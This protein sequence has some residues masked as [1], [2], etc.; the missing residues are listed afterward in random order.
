MSKKINPEC[1]ERLKQWLDIIN[2]NQSE[3]AR[4]CGYS[5]PYINSVIKGKKKLT[6]DLAEIVHEKTYAIGLYRF[7]DPSKPVE[8]FTNPIERVRTAWLLCLDDYMTESDLQIDFYQA[9]GQINRGIECMI[10]N[11]AKSYGLTPIFTKDGVFLRD[12]IKKGSYHIPGEN[13]DSVKRKVLEV[14]DF[15]FYKELTNLEINKDNNEAHVTSG[16]I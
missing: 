11:S 7:A 1:G 13:I 4:L 12:E 14:V 9:A 3:L 6:I 5:S 15:L 2:M 16:D 8:T 10:E